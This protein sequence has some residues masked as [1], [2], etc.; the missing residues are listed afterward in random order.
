MP[1]R[2]SRLTRSAAGLSRDSA[3]AALKSADFTPTLTHTGSQL[4]SKTQFGSAAKADFR[5][6]GPISLRHQLF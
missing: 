4:W 3:G 2:P 6:R 1:V 5:R